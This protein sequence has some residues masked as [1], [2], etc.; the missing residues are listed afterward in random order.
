M[1]KGWLTLATFWTPEVSQREESSVTKVKVSGDSLVT[2]V[3]K[4]GLGPQRSAAG[5]FP[6]FLIASAKYNLMP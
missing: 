6:L 1:D 3:W 4:S 2:R 5:L